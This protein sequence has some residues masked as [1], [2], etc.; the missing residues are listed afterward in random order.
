[1]RSIAAAMP[2]VNLT[3]IGFGVV[4]QASV[5]MAA[6]VEAAFFHNPPVV[7]KRPTTGTIAGSRALPLTI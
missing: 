4:G 5:I 7:V 6:I 2:A 1:M 3:Y